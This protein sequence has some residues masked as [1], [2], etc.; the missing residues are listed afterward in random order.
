MAAAAAA[1]LSS[2]V[3][4]A[5]DASAWTGLRARLRGALVL[6][7]DRAYRAAKALFD[8]RFDNNAPAGVVEVAHPQDVQAAVV[9]A[10]EH[11]CLSPPARAGTRLS[12]RPR[13]PV[14]S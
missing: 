7:E 12:G 9:F 2:P 3:A 13:P 8:P 11:G 14:H 1:T 4:A 5:V 6:P 10:G